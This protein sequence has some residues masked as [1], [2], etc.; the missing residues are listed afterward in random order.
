MW[1]TVD[2]HDAT[3]FEENAANLLRFARRNYDR[4]GRG[5]V[6][7][8]GPLTLCYLDMLCASRISYVLVDDA[9]D[10]REIFERASC[11]DP[12]LEMVVVVLVASSTPAEVTL[13]FN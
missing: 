7:I 3:W 1:C 8:E 4:L 9:M 5:A 13:C 6:V 12:E 2:S 10:D 11:Y